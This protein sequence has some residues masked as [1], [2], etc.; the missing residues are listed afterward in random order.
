MTAQAEAPHAALPAGAG[1]VRNSAVRCCVGCMTLTDNSLP[2]SIQVGARR[3][4]C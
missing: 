1:K 3:P 4:S 2:T